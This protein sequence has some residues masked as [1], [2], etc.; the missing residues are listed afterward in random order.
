M[1]CHLWW[2]Y[3]WIPRDVDRRRLRC[4]LS[5]TDDAT[6]KKASWILEQVGTCS[7]ISAFIRVI[8]RISTP[9]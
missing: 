6:F 1:E 5:D 9:T 7:A 2:H 3:R 4:W 8:S